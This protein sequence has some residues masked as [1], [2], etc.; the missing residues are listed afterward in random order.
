MHSLR[1]VAEAIRSRKPRAVFYHHEIAGTP[2]N[3]YCARIAGEG[4]PFILLSH[5]SSDDTFLAA[6]TCGGYHA[7]GIPLYSEDIVRALAG[8]EE[9]TGLARAAVE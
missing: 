4:I 2:W 1:D 6:L 8:A 9:V 5:K 7:W 3:G